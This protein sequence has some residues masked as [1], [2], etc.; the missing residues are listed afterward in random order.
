[1][2]QNMIQALHI[3]VAG[4][5]SNLTWHLV[6]KKT[7]PMQEKIKEYEEKIDKFFE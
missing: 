2:T 3:L 5:L 4:I 6:L 1:M 7:W